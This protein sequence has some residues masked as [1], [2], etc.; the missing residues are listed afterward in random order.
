MS[1]LTAERKT[2]LSALASFLV[3]LV[4]LSA[5]ATYATDLTPLPD[6]LEVPAA[7]F[8]L[9]ATTYL[10]GYVT[11]HRP[12]ELSQSAIDAFRSRLGGRPGYTVPAQRAS[13]MGSNLNPARPDRFA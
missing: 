10:T 2:K 11:R 8:V 3:A 1:I 9:Y 7:S 5:L 12:E 6:W 4:G 13:D